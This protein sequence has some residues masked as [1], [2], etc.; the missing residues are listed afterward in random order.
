MFRPEVCQ[1]Q[2]QILIRDGRHP[3]IDLLMGEQ[4]QYVPNNT[5]LQVHTATHTRPQAH[6]E[7]FETKTQTSA[8]LLTQTVLKQNCNLSDAGVGVG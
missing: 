2:P 6:S 1:S 4:N 8:C 5:E 7:S 3:A